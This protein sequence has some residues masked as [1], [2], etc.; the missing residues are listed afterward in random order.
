[1]ESTVPIE[2]LSFRVNWW[3]GLNFLLRWLL[4]ISNSFYFWLISWF[5]WLSVFSKGIVF[6]D[7]FKGCE[8]FISYKSYICAWCI[9]ALSEITG[10]DEFLRRKGGNSLFTSIEANLFFNVFYCIFW[11]AIYIFWSFI[12]VFFVTYFI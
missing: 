7:A 1:M 4:F 3:E 9:L 12:Y 11:I 5:C 10:I 8:Q 6:E 2:A